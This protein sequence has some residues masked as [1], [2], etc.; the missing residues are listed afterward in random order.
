MITDSIWVEMHRVKGFLMQIE[1]YTDRKRNSNRI[2]NTVIVCSSII[3]AVASFFH[4]VPYVPWI[5]ILSAML[6]AVVTCL[7]ELIPHFI[8]PE[9]ELCELD[10]IHDF[11]TV[12]LQ[13][14]EYL[15]VQRFDKHS[16][17]DDNAMNDR[18]HELMKTEGNRMTRIN[19]LCRKIKDVEK[20]RI[21]EETNNYFRTK[22]CNNSYE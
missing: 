6:V 16:N 13:E 3:C 14:L 15:Y 7:K 11:Y 19:I 10:N 2:L 21:I 17:V 20:K 22:Y 5:S 8:Q 4:N 12:L 18:F 9:R 1:L